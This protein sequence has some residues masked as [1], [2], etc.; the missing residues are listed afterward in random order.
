MN[1]LS[2]GILYKTGLYKSFNKRVIYIR[3]D[4]NSLVLKTVK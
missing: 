3:A 2:G 4:D 1:L